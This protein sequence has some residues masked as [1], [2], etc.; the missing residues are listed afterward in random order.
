MPTLPADPLAESD[1]IHFMD[2]LRAFLMMLGVVLHSAQV[3]NPARE[4]AISSLCS[5]A[6][7]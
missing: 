5:R 3:F 4:W 1:R 6:T 2:S 7:S